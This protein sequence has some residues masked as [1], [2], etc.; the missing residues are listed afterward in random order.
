MA[1]VSTKSLEIKDFDRLCRCNQ[2]EDETH[3]LFCG[4]N[5][6]TLRYEFSKIQT[7]IDS[8]R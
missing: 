4:K 8:Y 6:K 3:L 7:I 1:G 2:I 5:Y